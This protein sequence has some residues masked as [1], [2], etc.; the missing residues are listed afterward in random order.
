L[1]YTDHPEEDIALPKR[2]SHLNLT[3]L[4]K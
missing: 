4:N 1:D 2:A 3:E